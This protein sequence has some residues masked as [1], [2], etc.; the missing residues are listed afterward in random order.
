MGSFSNSSHLELP[1]SAA[2][3]SE[4]AVKSAK[5]LILKTIGNAALTFEEL[6]T[7]LAEVEVVLN[8][9]LI[10]VPSDDPSE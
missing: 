8:S 5:T 3:K 9:R 7:L 2:F 4:W 6:T 10:G 1:T